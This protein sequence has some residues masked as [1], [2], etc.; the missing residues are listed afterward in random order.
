MAQ[1]VIFQN[2]SQMT[3][4]RNKYL[5]AR[6]IFEVENVNF[7]H[8]DIRPYRCPHKICDLDRNYRSIHPLPKCGCHGY[9]DGRKLVRGFGRDQYFY[10]DGGRLRQATERQIC[11]RED[12][13]AGS[14]V[15]V[16][17]PEVSG[18]ACDG[19]VCD[20]VV[21]SYVFT[22]LT[23]LGNNGALVEGSPSPPSDPI[24]TRANSPG[25]TVSWEGIPERYANY[26]IV[27]VRLYRTEADYS[28]VQ[29]TVQSSE[30]LLVEEWFASDDL[31]V[32]GAMSYKDEFETSRTKYPLLTYDPMIFPAPGDLVAATRTTDGIVVAD[33]RRIYISVNGQPMFTWDGVVEVEQKIIWLESIGNTI[34]VFTE[35]NPINISYSVRGKTFSI[36]K[37]VI[38]RNLPV[39]SLRSISN[40]RG[41]I[42]FAS[43]Y[44]LYA[45]STDRYGD[46]IVS[47]LNPFIS[48]EQWKNLDPDTIVGTQYEYGYIFSSDAIDYSI[49]LEIN[50]DGVDTQ[51][52]S[53]IMK[54]T[55]I[56][57]P[58][59]FGLDYEGNIVYC[60]NREL[61]RWNFRRTPCYNDDFE[62][63]EHV[64][65]L[66]CGQCGCCQWSIKFFIDNE[67]KNHFS[68]MRVE[69]DER[70]APNLWVS[71]H[72]H[73]FGRE[74]FHTEEMEIISSRGFGLPFKNVGY[75]SCYVHLR[76]CGIVH[77]IKVATSAQELVYNSNNGVVGDE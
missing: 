47:V 49:I 34:Y 9:N 28:D 11:D 30:W 57:N 65:P 22:Y 10:V 41:R 67:G 25:V 50:D 23:R 60:E 32:A 63:F 14:P 31:D 64:R 17:A 58:M 2:I 56:K 38:D 74:I 68:H 46:N 44:S 4:W 52:G 40:Y 45:W 48:P 77:Q 75:Q 18:P 21:V 72:I 19:D 69:W 51:I 76:G 5:R 6:G 24:V 39:S 73:E 26:P 62:I 13:L 3:P 70:S 37:T 1:N 54:F 35:K 8:G 29:P 33:E 53:N 66:G 42:I 55:Y 15:P 61:W 12:V 27:G 71:F 20:G 36:E 7:H 16:Q 43:E 59:S